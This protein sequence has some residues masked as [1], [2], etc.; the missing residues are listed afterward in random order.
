M[1]VDD[2]MTLVVVKIVILNQ[3]GVLFGIKLQYSSSSNSA[4]DKNGKCVNLLGGWKKDQTFLEILGPIIAS[5]QS[6]ANWMPASM[7]K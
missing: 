1:I 5:W 4:S 3:L 2:N 6:L 7:G